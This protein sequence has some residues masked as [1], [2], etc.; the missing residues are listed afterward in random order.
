MS[1][2]YPIK[3]VLPFVKI[4]GKSF[5]GQHDQG[6]SKHML[7][8]YIKQFG[9]THLLFAHSFQ[10]KKTLVKPSHDNDFIWRNLI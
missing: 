1:E 10:K 9:P 8:E 6:V 5:L 2:L 3:T 7:I 4:L